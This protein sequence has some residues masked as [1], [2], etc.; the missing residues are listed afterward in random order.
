[1]DPKKV[2][3]L[4]RYALG[5]A[6][7]K[8]PGERELGEIHILKFL[9]LA[10][11]A[12]AE[13]N[14][15]QTF[16]GTPWIFYKFGPWCQP[17]QARIRPVLASCGAIERTFTSPK[18]EGEG[19]RWHLD[20]DADTIVEE[21]EI[22][23]PWVVQRAVKMAVKRF[24]DDTTDLLHHVYSTKPMLKAAPNEVLQFEAAES[25]QQAAA[26]EPIASLTQRQQ[27]KQAEKLKEIRSALRARLAASRPKLVPPDPPPR[28]DEIFEAG[29]RALDADAGGPLV[30]EAGE[31]VFDRTVWKSRGRS[32]PGTP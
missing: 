32:D 9:Y 12:Y 16:T 25:R 15:G 8:D 19:T 6:G 5:V 3:L 23:L 20:Q 29:V 7:L 10:D 14:G 30:V 13:S 22:T 18:F 2:D 28:Y 11:L 24:G 31:L 4:I 17:V 27:K 21:A 26:L 1:M